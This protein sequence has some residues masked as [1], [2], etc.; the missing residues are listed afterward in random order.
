MNMDRDNLL[1]LVTTSAKPDPRIFLDDSKYYIEEESA[2]RACCCASGTWHYLKRMTRN[3]IADTSA[4][5]MA[6]G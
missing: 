4:G 1:A 3:A 2:D 6:H 5:K